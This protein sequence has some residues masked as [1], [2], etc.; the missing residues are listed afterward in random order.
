MRGPK[1]PQ[2]T[3]NT[4]DGGHRAHDHHAKPGRKCEPVRERA[5]SYAECGGDGETCGRRRNF[6]CADD[7]ISES[8]AAREWKG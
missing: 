3:A 7:G 1:E 5:R 8:L 6:H 2:D 4:K